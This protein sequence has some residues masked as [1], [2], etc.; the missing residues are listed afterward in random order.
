MSCDHPYHPP[1]TLGG[2][3]NAVGSTA[4]LPPSIFTTHLSEQHP[5]PHQG[6]ILHDGGPRILHDGG[7]RSP[8]KQ[9]GLLLILTV[10]RE[11]IQRQRLTLQFMLI[12]QNNNMLGFFLK[13]KIR[14]CCN[15]SRLCGPALVGLKTPLR[16][17]R[18]VSEG[19]CKRN[20]CLCLRLYAIF[21]IFKGDSGRD[22]ERLV[23]GRNEHNPQVM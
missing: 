10:E 22:R 19:L 13:Q 11:T 18:D 3:A 8:S 1:P 2:K 17:G 9:Q 15:R 12:S 5:A 14:N 4:G 21:L 7:P 20:K 16:S 6:R 23:T